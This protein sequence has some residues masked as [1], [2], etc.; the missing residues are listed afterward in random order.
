MKE[1]TA[2]TGDLVLWKDDGYYVAGIVTLYNGSTG[3][4]VRAKIPTPD[5]W[6]SYPVTG[7]PRVAS[8]H[9]FAGDLEAI[10]AV[11]PLFCNLGEARSYFAPHRATS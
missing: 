1:A 4:A 11:A 5:G 7:S 9:T 3:R 8:R 2:T 6:R 10:V